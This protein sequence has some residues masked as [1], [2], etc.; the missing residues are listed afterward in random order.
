MR[1]LTVQYRHQTNLRVGKTHP[2]Q[3]FSKV[4]RT[5]PQWKTGLFESLER[6]RY[7]KADNRRR[8]N[9]QDPERKGFIQ[10]HTKPR[11]PDK[12]LLALVC[13]RNCAVANFPDYQLTRGV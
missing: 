12:L 11:T 3:R 13:I 1:D 2:C 9:E 10:T 8:S 6:Q 7:C 4:H 5:S